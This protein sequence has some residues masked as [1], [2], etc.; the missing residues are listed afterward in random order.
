[1]K[2]RGLAAT[3]LLASGCVGAM[4]GAPARAPDSAAER[5]WSALADGRSD[6]ARAAFAQALARAP[7]DAPAL[8]GVASLAYEQAA[9]ESAL[10]RSLELLEAA[11]RGD[12]RAGALATATLARM[13]RLL[14][15]IPDRRPAEERLL[16]LPPRR[17]DWRAQ[18]ALGLV[19]LDIARMRA[20]EVLLARTAADLGCAGAVTYVGSGGRLPL[21]DLPRATFVPTER[22]R[23][24]L[25]EGCQFR[26]HTEDGR[27]G[28]KVLR[29][30]FDLPAGRYHVV[31]D[32]GGAARLRIDGG[33]WHTHAGSLDVF[34]WT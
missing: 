8:F 1:M 7:A 30:E 15:E 24:L 18:Y 16:A 6:V 32:F 3:L 2:A 4:R 25:A 19:L 23:P 17:L 31:F 22:P 12:A 34:Q 13:P 14:A 9:I 21:L 33:P 28:I 26:L 11:S 27:M 10:A 29:S 20:D 5:G